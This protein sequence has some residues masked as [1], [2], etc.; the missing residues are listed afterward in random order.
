MFVYLFADDA[1]GL[2]QKL[3]RPCPRPTPKVSDNT[4]H[5]EDQWEI[6]KDK[7]EIKRKLGEG[8]FGEVHL[9]LMNGTMPVAVKCLRSESEA[10]SQA[11]LLEAEIM[12]KYRHKRLVALFAV[13]TKDKPFYIV[14]EYI[15]KGTL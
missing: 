7:L 5:Y 15:S 13:C 10:T 12:K 2:C 14:Q 6:S 11:F 8:N 9:A 4:E 3:T 1:G